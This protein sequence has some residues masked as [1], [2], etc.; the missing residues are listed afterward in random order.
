M[1]ILNWA[2]WQNISKLSIQKYNVDCAIANASFITDIG[3]EHVQ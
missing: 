2:K 1:R 3:F